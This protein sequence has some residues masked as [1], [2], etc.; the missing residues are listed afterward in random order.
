MM[1]IV[2]F[3][4]STHEQFY[5]LSLT[6]PVWELRLGCFSAKE[7]IERSISMNPNIFRKSKVYYFTRDYL[8]SFYQKRYEGININD[9]SFLESDRMTLFINSRVL[10][11]HKFLDIERNNLYTIDGMPML[12]VV[13]GQHIGTM[14][15]LASTDI[16]GLLLKCDSLSTVNKANIERVD[17]IWDLIDKNSKMIIEDFISLKR[18]NI[19]KSYKSVTIIGDEEQLLIEDEVRID[20]FVCIDLTD[21]PVIIR[22]GTVINSF[23]RIEGPCYIG[24]NC[25]ILGARIRKGCSIGN[26]CRLGGEV[27]ESIFHGYSNKY[28]DGFIGHAYIGE[29]VNLG[30]LTTNS[31]LKNDYTP[32]KTYIIDKRI[33]TGNL[34]VGCFVGDFTRT[35]VGCLINTGS[36]IGVGCMLVHAGEITPHHVPSFTWFMENDLSEKGGIDSILRTCKQ[37]TSR[38]DVDFNEEYESLL[39]EVYIITEENRD[40]TIKRWREKA[41]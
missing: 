31:D 41:R 23:T 11:S 17:Y 27:E 38:R 9:Y 35:S 34:K 39:K 2:V 29:W 5:P 37:M 40:K 4:D 26:F 21:G 14:R 7:R 19:T 8:K 6:R 12:A 18:R 36:S 13:D 22:R 24:E 15:D 16:S 28:H 1:N 10:P 32:V 25:Q 30:A 20:P 33:N 3:D